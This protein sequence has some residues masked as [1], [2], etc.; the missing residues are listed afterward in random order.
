MDNGVLVNWDV[1][2]VLFWIICR[3][4]NFLVN[5]FSIKNGYVNKNVWVLKYV[6]ILKYIYKF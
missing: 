5:R 3:L 2:G 4:I 1:N 6:F